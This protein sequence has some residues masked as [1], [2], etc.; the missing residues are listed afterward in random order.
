MGVGIES[1]ADF[2]A[3]RMAVVL[4]YRVPSCH[5][6]KNKFAA[7]TETCHIVSG[8]GIDQNHFVRPGHSFIDKNF[9]SAACRSHISEAVLIPAVVLVQFDTLCRFFAYAFY[10]FLFRVGPVGSL[11][12][13]DTDVFIGNAGTV[14]FID[15]MND[16]IPCVVPGTGDIGNDKADFIAG[17]DLF[18]Q[19][20]RFCRVA[21]TCKR[22]FFDIA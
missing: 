10:I 15:D 17:T 13:N 3:Q 8:N 22:S 11:G 21:H 20:S 7:T 4:L 2:I 5:A 14:Q 12:K 1:G 9:R 18:G 16:E 6:G 19:R